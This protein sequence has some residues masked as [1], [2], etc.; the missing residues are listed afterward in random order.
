V[1]ESWVLE[2]VLSSRHLHVRRAPP[3]KAL[4]FTTSL[5]GGGAESHTLRVLNHLDRSRFSPELAVSRRGGSYE[6]FL[7]S[8]LPVHDVSFSRIPSSAGRLL[9]SVHGLR[10]LVEREAY[11]V[12]CSVM[13][14]PNLVAL[15]TVM[16]LRQKPKLALVVQIPPTIEF[17]GKPFGERVLLPAM[18]RLY[19][20]ADRVIALSHGVKRDLCSLAP[21]LESMTSVIHN[22]C[23]DDRLLDASGDAAA[24]LPETSRPVVVAVGRLTYQKGY[25]HLLDAFARVRRS[26]DAELWILGDGPDRSAI[27]RQIADLGLRDVVR[28]L[29]FQAQ[30]QAFMRRA[31]V[32]VLSSLYEGFGNVVVEAL[33]CGTPVVSTECPHGPAEILQ[34]ETT[35]LLV[36]VAD[37]AA[38]ADALARL[39]GDSAL[40]ERFITAGRLRASAFHA[41]E[42]AGQ[43]AA[44]LERVVDG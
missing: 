11:D 18:K 32:F 16:T 1:R 29:G 9:A 37:S 36:P 34:N 41:R 23:V 12:I 44:E 20:Q 10:R 5:G 31:T 38:L 27:E 43:Y 40:R 14:L 6:R 24:S 7:R 21:A 33:A 25:P 26:V 13:D 4:F 28:L 19:P 17:K 2:H 3:Y 22:A 30:P 42:I 35:G 15:G 39:L 8:D